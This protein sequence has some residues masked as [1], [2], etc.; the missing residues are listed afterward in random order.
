MLTERF[1]LTDAA[2]DSAFGCI[3]IFFTFGSDVD[4]VPGVLVSS[5]ALGRLILRTAIML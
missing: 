2:L 3:R 5:G 4:G 1:S